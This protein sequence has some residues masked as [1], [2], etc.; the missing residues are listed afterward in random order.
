M[1]PNRSFSSIIANH[2]LTLKAE[3][4]ELV[5]TVVI[6]GIARGEVHSGRVIIETIPVEVSACIVQVET[7]VNGRFAARHQE[8]EFTVAG[9]GAS[10]AIRARPGFSGQPGEL[11]HLLRLC[12]KNCIGDS[13][14]TPVWSVSR[15]S[16]RR[17]A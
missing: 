13:A 2:V 7:V 10:T 17:A 16:E 12:T 1:K 11:L 8:V 15:R 14:Y 6:D 5:E 4:P 3:H 9:A